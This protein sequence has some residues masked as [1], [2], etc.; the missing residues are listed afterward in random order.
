MRNLNEVEMDLVGGG[1]SI[2]DTQ[3]IVRFIRE[4]NTLHPN[5]PL[6]VS[7]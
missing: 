3:E 5:N 2:T 1:E 4:W 7:D 6:P